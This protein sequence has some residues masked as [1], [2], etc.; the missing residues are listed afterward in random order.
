ILRQ[1]SVNVRRSGSG[2]LWRGLSATLARDVPFSALYWA[3]Y[4]SIKPPLTR[5]LESS[6]AVPPPPPLLVHSNALPTSATT[7]GSNVAPFAAGALAGMLAATVTTPLDV[8]KTRRQLGTHGTPRRIVA[9]LR[10]IARH[11]GI[12]GLFSGLVPRVAK[13]A[14]ACAIMIGT[15]EYGKSLLGGG[16]ES[17]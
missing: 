7:H 16:S 8:V 2:Y 13:V 17:L 3:T 11:E 4:E 1:V 5:M 15:Y 9:I 10:S 12:A 6:T 14:P